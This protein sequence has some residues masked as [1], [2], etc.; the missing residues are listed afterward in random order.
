M[1]GLLQTGFDLMFDR[2][3]GQNW[4]PGDSPFE[5]MVG[6]VLTQNTNWKNV[7][8]AI[9]NLKGAGL[10]SPSSLYMIPLDRISDLIRPA[11]YFRIKSKRL[12]NFLKFFTDE[13][14]A[15]I[16]FMKK[17]SLSVLREGLLSVSGL[18]P[19]T[20]DSMLLYALDKP[21]FVIDAYT[22]RIM[23]RHRLCS[24]DADYHELQDYFMSNLSED[25]SL[26]NEYHAL[27]VNVGKNFCRPKEPKC[28]ECPL[29]K[30]NGGPSL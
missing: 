26:Y 5:V 28:N 9:S 16:E 15:D 10:L 1:S 23:V 27:L 22:K 4:W 2:L 14:D 8:K 13:Y 21:I 6:A 17:K 30:W 12:K 25:V 7:E 11:G 20:V 3:G 24:E 19:E 18:G 29:Q